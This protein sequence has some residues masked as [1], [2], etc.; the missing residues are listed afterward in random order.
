MV[1]GHGGVHHRGR[2]AGRRRPYRC[3]SVADAAGQSLGAEELRFTPEYQ[4]SGAA[5]DDLPAA[6]SASVEPV[7][8]DGD[9]PERLFHQYAGYG[10]VPGGADRQADLRPGGRTAVDQRETIAADGRPARA[11]VAG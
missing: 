6:W 8:R 2:R 10:T 11:E 9:R 4:F 3:A 1:E 7:R 5:E